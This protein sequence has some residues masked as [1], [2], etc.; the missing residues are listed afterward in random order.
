MIEGQALT[1]IAHGTPV[2]RAV[3]EAQRYTDRTLRNAFSPGRGQQVP[4]RMLDPG[5]PPSS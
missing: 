3:A 4:R 2:T 1:L 5:D